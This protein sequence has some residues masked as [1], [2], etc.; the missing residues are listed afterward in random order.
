MLLPSAR[1]YAPHG[2]YAVKDLGLLPIT[3]DRESFFL[4][5]A[6]L[7]GG[8]FVRERG[9]PELLDCILMD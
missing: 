7:P 1:R 2:R 4:S 3:P 5:L 8:F 6:A 9:Q